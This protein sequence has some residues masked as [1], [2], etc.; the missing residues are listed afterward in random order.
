[1]IDLIG[2]K[3]RIAQADFS[4]WDADVIASSRF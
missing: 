3:G 2:I 1:M 4:L